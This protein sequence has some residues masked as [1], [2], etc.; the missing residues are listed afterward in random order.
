MM[1]RAIKIGLGKIAICNGRERLMINNKKAHSTQKPEALLNRIILAS[2]N[3][4]DLILDPF[5]GSG[6]TGAIAKK[7]NRKFIGIE[8]EKKYY[9][10]AKKRI[11]ST[12]QLNENYLETIPNKRKEK[13][14][15]FGYLVESGLVGLRFKP[16]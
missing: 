5:M 9:Q 4:K 1:D 10:I 11:F 8:K 15:P 6:T 7:L 16:F 13:R 3:Q 12:E 2:S 14:V